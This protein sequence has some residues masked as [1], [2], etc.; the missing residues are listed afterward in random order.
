[1]SGDLSEHFSRREF[2]CRCGCGYDAVAPALV[3]ALE[4][5]RDFIA[6]PITILNGCRCAAHNVAVGG[7]PDSEHVKG[8]AA[9]IRADGVP[10]TT[11]FL[12]AAGVPQ[13]HSGGIG[14]YPIDGFLHVDTRG[15]RARWGQIDGVYCSF[16]AAWDRARQMEPP[17]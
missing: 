7:K 11:L 9:D 15:Y 16:V 3:L 5:L 4:A 17:T 10:L 14:I 12:R 2:A 1:M 6:A 8:L 13:L